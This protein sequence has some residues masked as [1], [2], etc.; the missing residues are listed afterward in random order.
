MMNRIPTLTFGVALT[1]LFAG[2]T[3]AA[4]QLNSAEPAAKNAAST[5]SPVDYNFVAQA[6]LGAPFQIDSGRIA[7]AKAST[8]DIRDYAH[9][10]VTSHVPSST[11]STR[12]LGASRS[13][14]LRRPCCRAPTTQ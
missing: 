14:R 13:P 7:E 2:E 8:A 12:S 5:L 10:M 6:N 9:L 4:A 3:G 1:A 11:A